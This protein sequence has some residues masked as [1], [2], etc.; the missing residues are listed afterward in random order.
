MKIPKPPPTPGSA[1]NDVPSKPPPPPAMPT[2]YGMAPPPASNLHM[3]SAY[4]PSSEMPTPT[5]ATSPQFSNL[6]LALRKAREEHDRIMQAL[7]NLAIR[8][9][10]AFQ[11]LSPEHQQPQDTPFGPAIFYR[12]YDIGCLWAVYDMAMIVA[13]RSH[14]DMP[15]AAHMAVGI[16]A[17]QTMPY[18][19]EIGRIVAGIM[20]SDPAVSLNPSLGAALCESCVP[21]F[22]A[23][24]QY[25]DPHQ[26]YDTVTKIRE[27]SRRTGWGTAEV[28]LPHV[29]TEV[30]P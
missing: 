2:F 12:S 26:R 27:V 5:S 18:A 29:C 4:Q 28:S 13:I 1:T 8:L 16:A 6:D 17:Q 10:P 25:M 3:P 19:L 23:A 21:I 24:V 15:P 14:P 20:P 7:R 11:P 30:V 22:F 9:G